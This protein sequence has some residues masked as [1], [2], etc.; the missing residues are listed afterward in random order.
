MGEAKILGVL[1]IF[2]MSFKLESFIMLKDKNF[3]ILRKIIQD[4]MYCKILYYLK[5]K[6]VYKQIT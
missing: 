5:Y 6:K 1:F 3:S 4:K 2:S